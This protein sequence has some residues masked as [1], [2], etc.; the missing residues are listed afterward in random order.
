MCSECFFVLILVIFFLF[1][2]RKIDPAIRLKEWLEEKQKRNE[3]DRPHYS[4][5][6]RYIIVYDH[7]E[8]TCDNCG[9]SETGVHGWGSLGKPCEI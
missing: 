7:Y 6:I 3:A 8:F 4:H 2:P 9:S 1:L 5:D